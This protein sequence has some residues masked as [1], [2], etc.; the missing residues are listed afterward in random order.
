MLCCMHKLQ[1]VEVSHMQLKS[2]TAPAGGEGCFTRRSCI[3]DVWPFTLC[4]MPRVA[5]AH[6]L[7]LCQAPSQLLQVEERHEG[8]A[9]ND[10]DSTPAQN[11]ALATSAQ[12]SDAC[13]LPRLLL[14]PGDLY[15][16]LW[17]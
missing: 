6:G 12:V 15:A 16:C 3:V 1:A 10:E 14:L 4:C 17:P 13:L 11:A 5:G 8:A 2:Y 9:V 7:S